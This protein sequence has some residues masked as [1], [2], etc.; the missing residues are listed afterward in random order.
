MKR[1]LKDKVKRNLFI[2]GITGMLSLA[3][4]SKCAQNKQGK[5]QGVEIVENADKNFDLM[6]SHDIT[7]EASF[8]ALYEK[9][10]PLAQLSMFP[11]EVYVPKAYSDNSKGI[12]NTIGL[13]SYFYPQNGDPCSSVWILTQ[14]YVKNKSW[15]YVSGDDALLLSDGWCRYRETGRIYK[16]MYKKLKGC[17]IKPYEFAALFS[18]IYNNEKFGFEVCDFVRE[19]YSDKMACAHKFMCHKP[20]KG[21]DDGILK[22]HAHEALLYLN[23]NNYASQLGKL[24]IIH[25][26]NSKG[27]EYWTTSVSQ[28]NPGDCREL[29][30]SLQKGD[31]TWLDKIYKRIMHYMPKDAQ[32]VRSIV[33]KKVENIDTRANLL[34]YDD[35]CLTVEERMYGLWYRAAM[36]QY[37]EGNYE[38]TIEILQKLSVNGYQSADIHNDMAISYYH[39]GKYDSC[40]AECR[41]VLSTGETPY[42]AQANFN[43]GKAYEKIGNKEKALQNYKL[44]QQREPYVEAY[45]QAVNRLSPPQN[46]AHNKTVNRR[47]R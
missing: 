25:G 9:A 29:K 40:I 18:C 44:A 16:K 41:R 21:Y 36:L 34:Q 15:L 1:K 38:K 24:K 7:D 11:T 27:K 37:K 33:M 2:A 10:L 3:I 45:N 47:R 30:K 5:E 32:T 4:V 6:K 31:E 20:S 46:R 8:Q 39:M 42:F 17:S 22:R 28:L 35:D 14:E 12:S 43:A 19:N 23:Y 13:G 26:I